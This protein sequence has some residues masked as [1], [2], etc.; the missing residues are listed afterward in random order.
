M[1]EAREQQVKKN[2]EALLPIIDTLLTC[3]RQNIAI[4]GHRGEEKDIRA[5]TP[6]PKENDGNFRALL[7]YH[8]RQAC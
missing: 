3:A 4:R 5:D 1:D 7:R 2:R 8:I 6:D